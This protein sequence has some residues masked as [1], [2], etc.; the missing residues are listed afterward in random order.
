MPITSGNLEYYLTGTTSVNTDPDASLGGFLTSQAITDA[1]DN[2]LFDDVTGDES[3][4]GDTE[5][6]AL[7]FDNA[8]T[9]LTLQNT[10]GWIATTT[11]STDTY[12]ELWPETP[13]SDEIQTV[14][15]E[16]IEPTGASGNWNSSTTKGSG[17]DLTS[18]GESTGDIA[19]TEWV[20]IWIKRV[21]GSSASAYSGDYVTIKV[22]GETAASPWRIPVAV[23]LELVWDPEGNFSYRT[24]AA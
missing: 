20:G 16:S 4:S 17:F 1:D 2:N 23:A 13:T 10:K 7:G 6:R 11:P 18:E 21:V 14:A 15:S 9:T 22:E 5:Y 24:V 3:A 8:H 12:I 19:A